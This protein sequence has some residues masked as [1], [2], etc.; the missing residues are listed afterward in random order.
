MV[1]AELNELD[2]EH[3]DTGATVAVGVGSRGIHRTDRI[4]AEM[5]SYIKGQG[6]EPVVI[7]AVGSHGGATPEGQREVLEAL[8]YHRGVR[9]STDRY[10]NGR[11]LSGH[12]DPR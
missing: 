10:S 5:V 12:G 1:R 8:G 2:F 4:A 7:S 3:L 6:F 11:P 9:R